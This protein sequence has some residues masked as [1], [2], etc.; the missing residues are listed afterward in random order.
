MSNHTFNLQDNR[1]SIGALLGTLNI[2]HC[3]HTDFPRN[4][5]IYKW[6]TLVGRI[7]FLKIGGILEDESKAGAIR[8]WG[9][10]LNHVRIK[11]FKS[12]TN[13]LTKSSLKACPGQVL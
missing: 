8:T 10:L 2:I 5:P 3:R 13:A 12:I 6:Y 1:Y 7:Y 11:Y 9:W 4:A